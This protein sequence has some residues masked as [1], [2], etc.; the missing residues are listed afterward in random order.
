MEMVC[1]TLTKEERTKSITRV[2][3]DISNEEHAEHLAEL[4][5]DLQQKLKD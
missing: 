2:I 4:M 3:L 1:D 5:A